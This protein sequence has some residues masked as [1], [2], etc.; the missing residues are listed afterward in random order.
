MPEVL[1]VD[2]IATS[3]VTSCLPDSEPPT[4]GVMILKS[5]QIF[6]R[7]GARTPV[8]HVAGFDESDYV[9]ELFDR[10]PSCGGVPVTIQSLDGGPRPISAT[11]ERYP[12]FKGGAR[13]GQLT[14][15]GRL[16]AHSLGR[17]F[18]HRYIRQA[19]LVG[20]SYDSSLV[21]VRA[22]NRNRCLET[23]QYVLAGMY[24]RSCGKTA[25]VVVS[26]ASDDREILK[27]NTK[28]CPYLKDMWANM[29][30][31][32]AAIPE[33]TA[34]EAAYYARIGD[35]SDYR[36]DVMQLRDHIVMRQAHGLPV[37]PFFVAMNDAIEREAVRVVT[38]KLCGV[39]TDRH[40]VLP[41]SAGPILK[42]IRENF[43]AAIHD[44]PATDSPKLR[45]YSAQDNTL[46]T[47][48]VA[49]GCFDDRWPP[50]VADLA[51]ELYE[52]LNRNH[53]VQ[54][55]YRSKPLT[56]HGQSASLMSVQEFFG[57]TDKF[58]P[59]RSQSTV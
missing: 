42:M 48:L 38:M 20:S 50:Y 32:L 58:K 37:D 40:R 15:L 1:T 9:N 52:D 12:T 34:I 17:N 16:Q 14:A 41:L 3:V 2:E 51:F 53:W 36:L 8:K 49:M 10:T 35:G 7:H 25:P 31:L 22:T 6:F 24:G 18:R 30:A 47:L 19:R 56:L 55:L 28:T 23:A 44:P 57:V 5:I 39:E 54:V 59:I 27:P 21:Y 33:Y 13:A 45:L 26:T 43:E 46:T 4:S 11:Q 29:P